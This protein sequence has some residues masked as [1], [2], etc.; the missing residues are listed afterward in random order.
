MSARRL[1]QRYVPQLCFENVTSQ[2]NVSVNLYFRGQ[3]S[4]GIVTSSGSDAYSF[5]QYKGMGLVSQV[6]KDDIL[7]SLKGNL[8]IGR[9]D[10]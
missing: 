9:L 3:E 7:A 8:G 1:F 10:G 6:F 5:K 4:A 2:V